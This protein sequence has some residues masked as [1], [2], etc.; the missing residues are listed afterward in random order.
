MKTLQSQVE[1]DPFNSLIKAKESDAL[2]KYNE[3][4]D[5]E[6]KLL[7]QQAKVNWLREGDR[8]TAYFHK[9]IKGKRNLSKIN[10]NCDELGNRHSGDE[11]AYQFVNHFQNFLGNASNLE[12]MEGFEGIF[13]NKLIEE[14]A[15]YMVRDV[16][17]KEIHDAFFDIGDAKAPGPDGFTAKFFKSA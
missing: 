11:I 2:K 14:E 17:D 7:Y 3:A 15:G 4:L 13:S 5:D 12:S 1:K 10:S 6:E 9:V 8:N 16:T